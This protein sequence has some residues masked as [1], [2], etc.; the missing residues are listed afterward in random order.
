MD[1]APVSQELRDRPSQRRGT[2]AKNPKMVGYA[3]YLETTLRYLAVGEDTSEEVRTIVNG[4][5]VGL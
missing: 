1:S 4:V 5:H 3:Y 2:G